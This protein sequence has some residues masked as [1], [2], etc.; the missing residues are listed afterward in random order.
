MWRT[1]KLKSWIK[2]THIWVEN[3]FQWHLSHTMSVKV[4]IICVLCVCFST[5]R[6]CAVWCV[7]PAEGKPPAG[8]RK[9]SASSLFVK[10]P[11]CQTPTGRMTR[12]S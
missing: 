9:T 3:Y 10:T 5:R 2:N 7:E 1:R 11:A 8:A 6:E 12:S 4:L